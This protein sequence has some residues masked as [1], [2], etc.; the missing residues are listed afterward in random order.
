MLF[1]N[2]YFLDNNDNFFQNMCSLFHIKKNL[3]CEILRLRR[4][5]ICDM[6]LI[7]RSA[8]LAEHFLCNRNEVSYYIKRSSD[9]PSRKITASFYYHSF[10]SWIPFFIT[11]Y[12][13]SSSSA[14]AFFNSSLILI[15]CGQCCSHFPQEIHCEALA[16]SFRKAVHCK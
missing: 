14:A 16:V 15:C 2:C 9:S 8:I 13:T 4:V 3:A 7:R 6:F 11:L 10:K 5:A 1:K 12:F